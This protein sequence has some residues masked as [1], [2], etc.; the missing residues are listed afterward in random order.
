M[1]PYVRLYNSI[2]LELFFFPENVLLINN[3]RHFLRMHLLHFEELLYYPTA[4][5][6]SIKNPPETIGKNQWAGGAERYS[7]INP[8]GY[9]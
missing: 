9:F 3:G 5:R 4:V 6:F 7:Y 1:P 2:H 8:A